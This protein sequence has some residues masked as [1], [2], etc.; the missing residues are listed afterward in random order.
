MGMKGLK[1]VSWGDTSGYAV[2]GKAYVRALARAGMPVTWSP[3]LPGR[4][5]FVPYDGFRWPESDLEPLCNRPCHYDVVV[6]HT[7]PE[8]Y[9][10]WLAREREPGRRIFGYTVFELERIPP[11]WPG[12]LN[13]LD[14]VIVPCEW[15]RKTFR[16][17]GVTVPIHVVPHLRPHELGRQADRSQEDQDRARA[18]LIRRLGDPMAGRLIFYSIGS[19]TARKSMDRT[20]QAFLTAFRHEDPV[21]L[22]VKTGPMDLT[23]WHRRPRYLFRRRPAPVAET[24]D[25]L[26]R[27]CSR[28]PLVR[29]IADDSLSDGEMRAL[30]DM[31]DVYVSLTRSEGVGLGAFEAAAQGKPVVMTR[32]GGQLEYLSS[33]HAWLIDYRMTPLSD[34]ARWDIFLHVREWAEA[35]I[36]DAAL[37]L[38]QIAADP[39]AARAR[40]APLAREIATRYAESTITANF[41]AIIEGTC[42]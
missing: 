33:D 26:L 23:R 4:R 2:A 36:D 12:I 5:G 10:E 37:A 18:A 9:P 42:A 16:S 24:L 15:N 38:R 22:V 41:C 3:M 1:Y 30:Q 34:A 32:N 7:V 28:P 29:V 21:A 25:R 14:G 31:G 40:A 20:L 27:A 11:H 19:W 6:L 8:Y 39:A 17:S 35:S 13:Q